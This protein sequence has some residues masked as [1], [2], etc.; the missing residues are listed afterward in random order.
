MYFLTLL[1]NAELIIGNSSAGIR[2]APF[3]NVPTIDIG[4]RQSNRAVATSI[5]NVAHNKEI[6]K[7]VIATISVQLDETMNS[8]FGNG[9]SD[10]LFLKLLQS[11]ELWKTNCQK[12]FQDL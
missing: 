10:E 12:Q 6:I 11:K 1:K 4:T 8:D 9:K 3:Y 2:E 5:V 7:K